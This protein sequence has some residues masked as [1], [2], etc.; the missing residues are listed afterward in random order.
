M[1]A[2]SAASHIGAIT[3]QMVAQLQAYQQSVAGTK[4]TFQQAA[5]ALYAIKP[6]E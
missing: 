6:E 4:D 3:D 2:D 5:A 1:Q